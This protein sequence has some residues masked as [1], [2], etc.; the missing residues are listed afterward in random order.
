MREGT[1]KIGRNASRER[2]RDRGKL[3][4]RVNVR[5]TERFIHTRTHI[6]HIP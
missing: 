6:T 1:T 4:E 2:E 5:L 3:R